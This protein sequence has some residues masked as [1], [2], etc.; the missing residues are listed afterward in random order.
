MAEYGHETNTILDPDV[1]FEDAEIAT[2][3]EPWEISGDP[4]RQPLRNLCR[5][6]CASCDYVN[7][8]WSTMKEHMEE[9]QHWSESGQEWFRYITNTVL[10][11]CKICKMRVASDKYVIGCHLE[12]NHQCTLN[13]YAREHIMEIV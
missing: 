3:T 11:Q 6:S 2:Q 5:Y 1:N 8:D 7:V 9:N 12:E 10:H 4:N 13:D